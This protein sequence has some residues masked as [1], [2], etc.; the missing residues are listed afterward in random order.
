M[1]EKITDKS[2]TIGTILAIILFI[3]SLSVFSVISHEVV[4]EKEDWFDSKVFVFFESYSSPLFLQ[5]FRF[6]TF[7]GST[8]FLIPA[9]S[10][11]ITILFLKHRKAEAI[12]IAV[13]ASTSTLLMYGLKA[14]FAR[15]RPKMP[16]FDALS[17]Y[18]FPS[19][20]AMSSFV[21]CSTLVW[22][23]W[24][25]T[26]SIKQKWTLG[27]FLLVLSLAI[28]ISRIVLRFHYAS[29]VVGGFSLGAAYFL[30]FFELRRRMR[31]DDI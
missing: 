29:D 9:W 18:S 23:V 3:L 5:I 2:I 21:F 30:L 17:N 15:H 27:L 25:S 19:G 12:D 4:M 24:H 22:L 13:L 1:E 7:F 31:S 16:L 6:L 26:V 11:V 14:V 28:G 10:S 8:V 20:H